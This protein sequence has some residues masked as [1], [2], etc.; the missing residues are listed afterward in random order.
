VFM[1]P[2]GPAILIFLSPPPPPPP[3]PISIISVECQRVLFTPPPTCSCRP[4]YVACT[5]YILDRTGR[6]GPGGLPCAIGVRYISTFGRPRPGTQPPS[7][8]MGE[9]GGME[10]D[11]HDGGSATHACSSSRTTRTTRTNPARKRCTSARLQVHLL[12]SARPLP[13][14]IPPRPPLCSSRRAAMF[15][16]P[17][18]WGGVPVYQH[19]PPAAVVPALLPLLLF[20]QPPNHHVRGPEAGVMPGS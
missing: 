7:F 20:P 18:H 16:V 6:G 15:L 12:G 4:P 17:S 8:T 3:P 1:L 10:R 9:G 14:I 2:N 5:P 19:A 13:R 11:I